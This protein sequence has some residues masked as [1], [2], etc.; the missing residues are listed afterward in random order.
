MKRTVPI[1]LVV[2]LMAGC[3]QKEPTVEEF[4][5]EFNAATAEFERVSTELNSSPLPPRTGNQQQ[6]RFAL[7]QRLTS[8]AASYDP[9]IKKLEALRAPSDP[10]H[11]DEIRLVMLDMVTLIRDDFLSGAA[12]LEQNRPLPSGEAVEN[13][14]LAYLERMA[15]ILDEMGENGDLIRDSISEITGM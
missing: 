1:F 14:L 8:D 11:L 4:S 5:V 6:D 9:I 2:A 10:Q 12:E 15:Q 3:G 7:A 13:E